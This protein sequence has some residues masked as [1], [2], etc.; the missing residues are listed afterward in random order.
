M[1][2]FSPLSLPGAAG[3]AVL[4]DQRGARFYDFGPFRLD[5]E[6]EIL[7]R[8]GKPVSLTR[9]T[10][11]ILLVLV[12]RQ[13]EIV[14]KD[15]LIKTVW[16]DT[17][18]EEGNLTR[19]IFMLRKALGESPQDH[20][21]IITVAGQG[22][23]L[24]ENV[25]TVSEPDLRL[26]A[27]NQA[28]LTVE[29]R[30]SRRW[31]WIAAGIAVAVAAIGAGVFFI[32][33]PARIL[34]DKDTVL[35][36]GFSNST[37][38]S[39]FDETLRQ[40]MA[41]QLQQSPHLS[42]V[43]DERIER[44]LLMMGRPANATLTGD[45]ARELCQRAGAAAVLEGA[46]A[47]LGS[48]YVLSL[49]ARRCS[50]GDVL[51][52][53]QAQAPRKEDVLSA[54]SAI[55]VRFRRRVGESLAQVKEHEKPL[56]DA[57]TSSL[58][59]LKAYTTGVRLVSTSPAAAVPFFKRAIDLDPNFAMAYAWLARQYGDMNEFALSREMAAKAY[60]LR[61]RT[62]DPERFWIAADYNTQVK[63]NLEEARQ[64]CEVWAKTYPRDPVPLDMMAGIIDPVFGR[65][66]AAVDE[67]RQAVDRDPDFAP[68]YHQLAFRYLNSGRIDE[69]TQTLNAAYARKLVRPEIV[70]ERYDIAF[71]EH[72]TAT[73]D[74]VTATSD[75]PV[76]REWVIEHEALALAFAGELRQS[77][78]KFAEAERIANDG[79]R[80]ESAAL[81]FAAQAATEGWFGN[82]T[83]AA[84]R[85][86]AALATPNNAG[87]VYGAALAFALA[88]DLPHAEAAAADLQNRFSEDTSASISYLPV[89]RAVLALKRNRPAAAIDALRPSLPYDLGSPRTSI[90][91]AFGALYPAYVRGLAYLAAGQA[92]EAVAEFQKIAQHPG[93]VA[94]DS[95]G[96]LA[97]LQLA[98]AYAAAGNPTEARTAYQNLF[99]LWKNADPDLRLLSDARREYARLSN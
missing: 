28:S 97:E 67:A 10:F 17:F 65:Y 54:L 96:A 81:Y 43:S 83:E 27:A 53:E 84:D 77:R 46:I 78:E 3:M 48:Q 59:A 58:E 79:G 95:I 74:A 61:N 41:V 64:V 16:P 7:L 39:I 72:D 85:A 45:T 66:D 93:I 51:D 23:R 52:Q 15:D 33:R 89:L 2:K 37:G 69:A 12:Q 26:V 80:H 31:P 20:R 19:H 22:Y 57:T 34:G 29:V 5:A 60:E 92:E 18:V 30:E 68:S 13:N 8:D 49:R 82:R 99:V 44:T 21:Y 11:Q 4:H 32:A 73:Q 42:L 76:T 25:Q 50:N 55:A 70:L 62:S 24:A 91:A 94:A 9:K 88:G 63:E 1:L 86:K 98:R 38:D 40:G 14:S 71:V 47:P 6:R 56:P 36:A 90:H 87:V 75:D 35:L